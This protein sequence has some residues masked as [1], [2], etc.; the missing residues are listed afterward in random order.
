MKVVLSALFASAMVLSAEGMAEQKN[1][2]GLNEKALLT[3]LDLVLP[4]KLD[5][6]AETASLSAQNIRI[7]QRGGSSW[8]RFQ[9]AVDGDAD[10]HDQVLVRP[11]VRISQ[12]KRRAGDMAEGESDA[13]TPR[14]VIHMQ[15]CM[16]RIRQNIEVNLTDRT[17]FDYPF[18]I[19][20]EALKDFDAVVDPSLKFSAGAPRCA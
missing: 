17:S 6:G 18:L 7:F 10:K 16:G 12:I 11:L 13:Y 14:P 8:V 4:A 2:F 19:G 15:V 3:D 5:T 20:S 9:L 1:V